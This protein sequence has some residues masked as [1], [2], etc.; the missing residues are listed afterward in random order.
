MTIVGEAKTRLSKRVVERV[1]A[2]VREAVNAFPSKFLGR[3]ITV[4][5]CL[6]SSPDAI[7]EAGRMAL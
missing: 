6:R 2:R 5:C 1:I 7:E 4:V 3:V